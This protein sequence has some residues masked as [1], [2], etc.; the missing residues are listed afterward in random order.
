ML[1]PDG[2]IDAY[3]AM[4]NATDA[5]QRRILADNALTDDAVLLYPT[6]EA[7]GRDEAVA[8]G[9][10]FH[11]DTPGVQIVLRSGVEQHHGWV[12]V[13]WCIVH[14]DGSSGPNGQSVGELAA[15][16]RLCRV[17]GFRNPL[18]ATSSRPE[19]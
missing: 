14:A 6:F 2:A 16:G 7:H 4:W 3:I 12:R 9:E 1:T 15:D 5:D 17:V 10:R 11:Q 8:T 13:A 19:R 18:P